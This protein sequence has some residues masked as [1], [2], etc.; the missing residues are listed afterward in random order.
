VLVGFAAPF[1]L[2]VVWERLLHRI[3]DVNSVELQTRL[4]VLGEV[5]RL[6]TRSVRPGMLGARRTGSALRMFE[7]SIDSMRTC[8][9][10]SEQLEGMQTIAVTSAA[11]SE[12]KTSVASQLAVSLAQASG[13]ATLLIDGDLRSPDIHR[14]FGIPQTPGLA[15]VLAGEASLDEAIVNGAGQHV[16][17]LP[18]GKIHMSPHKALGNGTVRE[19]IAGLLPRYRYIVIDTPPILSAGESLLLAKAADA[20]LLCTMRD[21]SRAGQVKKACERLAS[22]GCRTVG[23]VLSGVSGGEYRYRY[24]SY[25]YMGAR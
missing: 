23:A 14:V 1:G 19:L 13:Q 15:E 25:E 3:S 8:L 12:G 5:P 22:S 7:E 6:P 18:A 4:P 24:G 17:L 11:S 16:H 20:T 2:A 10:L 9:V 21:V